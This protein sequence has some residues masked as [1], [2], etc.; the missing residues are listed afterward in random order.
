M[1]CPY[2]QSILFTQ[3]KRTTSLGYTIFRCKAC[4]RDYNERTGTPFNHLQVPTDIVFEVLLCRVCYKLSYR[5]VAEYFLFRGFEFTHETVRDWEEQFLPLFTDQIRAKRKGKVGKIW[6]IDETYVRVKE[7][8]CYLYRGIDEYG[9]L[10]DVRL[11]KTRDMEGTK[12][13][14]ARARTIAEDIPERVQTD[15]LASY[16]RA[17]EEELG[18]EVKHEVLPCTANAVEQSHRGIK[19]RYF[20]MMGF[21]EFEAAQ[22]FCQAFDEVRNFLRHRSQMAEVVSLNERRERFL[23]KVSE[24]EEI[25]LAG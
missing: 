1:N 11:S 7:V 23:S 16:P 18:E 12:A 17:V 19:H 13:F 21:G 24:L 22:R 8:W 6:K 14:F 2:C 3:L 25:F 9:N 4:K 5:D 20:P 15:G 10:M